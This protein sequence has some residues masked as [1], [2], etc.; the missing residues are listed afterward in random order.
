MNRRA[1][2]CRA[3]GI[4]LNR[5]HGQSRGIVLCFLRRARLSFG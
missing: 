1:F 5:N 4:E 2:F 3:K